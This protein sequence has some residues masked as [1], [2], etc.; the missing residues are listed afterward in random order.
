MGRSDSLASCR[1]EGGQELHLEPIRE[2]NRHLG[3][4]PSGGAVC[5]FT[6]PPMFPSLSPRQPR[7]LTQV[8]RVLLPP[9]LQSLPQRVQ[10]LLMSLD[11]TPRVRHA[12]AFPS[13]ESGAAG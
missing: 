4:L 10:L 5:L 13:L 12:R 8:P 1:K 2:R 6:T 11:R 7:S 3:Q 9:P